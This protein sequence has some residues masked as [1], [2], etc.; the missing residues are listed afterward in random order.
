MIAETTPRRG[1][2]IGCF[3]KVPSPAVECSL[4]LKSTITPNVKVEELLDSLLWSKGEG[5][6]EMN[7]YQ[8]TNVKLIIALLAISVIIIGCERTPNTSVVYVDPPEGG[9]ITT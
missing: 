2:L 5:L 4:I 9:S 7:I 6:Q 3:F 1:F 8:P